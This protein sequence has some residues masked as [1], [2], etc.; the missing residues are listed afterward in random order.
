MKREQKRPSET[1]VQRDI[2]FSV[3]MWL[4]CISVFASSLLAGRMQPIPDMAIQFLVF[5]IAMV[6]AAR[7]I[8]RGSIEIPSRRILV[9]TGILF[10]LLSIS[11]I[12]SESIRLS[13]GQ[14][15]NFGS[16]LILFVIVAGMGSRRES[17]YGILAALCISA[18]VVS[19]F[20]LREYMLARQPGWRV[21]GTFFNPDF[22]AGFMAMVLPVA[23]AW[24][25]SRTSAGI[26]LISGLAVAGMFGCLLLTGSRFGAVCG[27]GGVAVTTVLALFARQIGRSQ[28]IRGFVLLIPVALVLITQGAPLEHRVSTTKAESH[29]GSFRVYTWKGTERMAIANPANGTGL[30]TFEIA[31]PRYALVGYTKLAHNS[32]LQVAGEAGIP[33][34]LVLILLV[35]Y[36]PLMSLS[37]L[38]RRRRV[39]GGADVMRIE[40][41]TFAWVPETGLMICGLIG[42]VSA[43]L[44]R[45]LVDSDWYVSAI[46]IAFCVI[47]GAM[48][49]LARPEERWDRLTARKWLT[50]G[51]AVLIIV[52]MGMSVAIVGD[53]NAA[54]AWK[55]GDQVKAISGLRSASLLDPLNAEYHR[56][57]AQVYQYGGRQTEYPREADR[58]LIAATGLERKNAKNY[59][60]LAR[61]YESVGLNSHAIDA[62]RMAVKYA[63]NAVSV[64]FAMAERLEK[65]GSRDDALSAWKDML[66]MEKTPVARVRAVPEIVEPEYIFA[67]YAWG[68]EYDSRGERSLANREYRAALDLIKL[69]QDSL[70]K[71]GSLLD[72]SGHRNPEMESRVEGLRAELNRR[73]IGNIFTNP[74]DGPG[75]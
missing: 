7:G 48:I 5:V 29:S 15:A 13:L 63:P 73:L 72:I 14:L 17:I 60:Q 6:F 34:A 28:V 3:Q 33:A 74:V 54:D 49:A 58:E 51:M 45:N 62:F 50:A 10:C 71:N 68:K 70:Q 35:T 56:Q 26:T 55:N 20:G 38:V 57:L 66:R 65:S 43:S 75:R 61:F 9:L 69:Y 21:F 24:Y 59:Y 2:L 36:C 22:L 67:H 53:L 25:L 39:G 52:V 16:Y 42:A 46:G 12:G 30:G 41:E 47:M 40:G 11:C 19:A 37:G 27:L 8:R 1:P 32:Y 64:R 44:A 23:L 31:Y 18:M 4:L